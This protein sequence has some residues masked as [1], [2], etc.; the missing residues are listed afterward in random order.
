M[1]VS[2]IDY[3]ALMRVNVEVCVTSVEEAVA[4]GKTGVDS[5]EL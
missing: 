1:S 3:I 2:F 5:V 4:A